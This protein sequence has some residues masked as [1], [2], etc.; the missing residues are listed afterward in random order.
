MKKKHLLTWVTLLTTGASL[1]LFIQ[2][3]LELHWGSPAIAKTS[4]FANTKAPNQILIPSS[5]VKDHQQL[6][7]SPQIKLRIETEA[8][9]IG[10]VDSNPEKTEQNLDQ[11]AK[12]LTADNLKDLRPLIFENNQN[13]DQV[14]LSLDLLGRTST[15]GASE[16][17]TDYILNGAN[18]LQIESNTFRLLALDSLIEQSLKNQDPSFLR[19]IK[20]KSEDAFVAKRAEQALKSLQGKTKTPSETDTQGLQKLLESKTTTN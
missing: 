9:K 1:L 10:Q 16:L 6:P 17:L 14:A 18:V 3:K 19:Q 7:P 13:G 15:P 5:T 11:L 2:W 20:N 8:L 12:S 4:E